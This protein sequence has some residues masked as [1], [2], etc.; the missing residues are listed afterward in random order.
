MSDERSAKI[1]IPL[2]L[3]VR[4]FM[5]YRDDVPPLDFEGIHLA[6]LT[7]ANGHGKSAILDAITWGLWGKA[8]A[9]RDDEL[10]HL[11]QSEM[12]VEFTFDLGGTVYRV[13]RKR[14]SAKRGRTLLD[15]QVQ[16]QGAFRSMAESTIRATQAAI[17]HLLRMDYETFTN[18]AFL[19][20][21]KADAFTTRTPA[22][23]KRVLG[24]ILGL[25]LYDEYEQRA[26]EKAKERDREVAELD[27]LL[28]DVDRELARQPEYESELVKAEA[29][30]AELGATVKEAETALRDLRQEQQTLEHQQARLQ[31]LDRRLAQAEQ[32][33]NEVST[34]IAE[35]SQRLSDYEA[36]LAE[37]QQVEEG[38]AAL[39]KAR[40]AEVRWN[41]RLTQYA[42]VQDRQR[43]VERAV[44]DARRELDLARGSLGE[45]VRELESRATKLPQHEQQL[46]E[47]RAKLSLLSEREAERDAAQ[48]QVQAMAE[49]SAGLE[50][51][52]EQ[53]RAEMDALK[54]KLALLEQ[55]SGEAQCPLCEQALSDEHRDQLVTQFQ[56]A[57]KAQADTHRANTARRREIEKETEHLKAEIWQLERELAARPA[58]QRREAQ[59]ETAL[60][61]AGEAASELEGARDELAALDAR[62]EA[63]DYAP[64]EQAEL[65]HLAG[66]LEA[67]GYDKDAHDQA[68]TE[69]ASLIEFEA[70]HHRLEVALERVPEERAALKELQGRQARWQ[71]TLADDRTRREALAVEVDRL[72]EVSALVQAMA[73]EVEELQV[74]SSNARLALGAAQ[75]K[76][77]H[78]HDLAKERERHVASRKE[79]VEEKAISDELRLAFGKKGI[80]AMII[81]AAIPE[82][83]VEANRLLARMTDGRMHVRFETQRETLKGDTIETLDINIADELG[84][85]PYELF[86]GGEA[87]RVNFAIRIAL[88]KLLARRAGAQLQMLVIDEGFGTQDAEGRGRL[89]EA[90]NSI[91]DDFARI[92]VITHIEELK[93]AFPVRI[94]VTKTAQGS[95]F[96]LN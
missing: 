89:V 73:Q 53:L 15:L 83:E 52:N 79:K 74:Q 81:E 50:V 12:E 91:Q 44:D 72:P 88:S 32:E 29:R 34:Q 20:Q 46:A 76:L 77:E 95:Q 10:I 68:R 64:A 35:R 42:Q 19:L 69:S 22:E 86:S 13:L 3:R 39:I 70:A 11:G 71:E 90:I 24:E 96:S 21:G 78:C 17:I 57:G 36:T 18:S 4:N 56:T 43:D 66:E 84:T 41:E 59:L 54:E 87:F 33:V 80:Q 60:A 9:R 65:A 94:E 2:Q 48:A 23:R 28:R 25:S 38:Y 45:R 5:C 26:K 7:G 51:R 30:V 14:D 67:L 75:Q 16:H 31:D 63:G 92:L 85:R 55:E 58:Q 1:M 8:R 6:C 61:E 82:I 47:V 49:E 37:R 62:L 27:G 93:D 40:E